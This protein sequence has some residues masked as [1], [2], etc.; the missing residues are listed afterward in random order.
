MLRLELLDSPEYDRNG[1]LLA[2]LELED[3]L[4]RFPG[5]SLRE[6]VLA[7]LNDCLR[8]LSSSDLAIA[9]FYERVENDQGQ[10]F[11][12]ERAKK[13]AQDANDQTLFSAAQALISTPKVQDS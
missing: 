2:Q 4:A 11:H 7:S 9:R 10:L 1:L 12:A 13:L 8:R 5:H 6:N 3:W